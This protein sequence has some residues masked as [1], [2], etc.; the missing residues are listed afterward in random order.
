[1][2]WRTENSRFITLLLVALMSGAICLI[3]Q[4]I[5]SRYLQLILGVSAYAVALVLTCFMLGLAMGSWHIGRLMDRT[6]HRGRALAIMESAI[7]IYILLSPTI[8]QWIAGI[9]SR[10][11][12]LGMAIVSLLIPTYLMGGT[13][14]AFVRLSAGEISRIGADAGLLYAVNTLGGAIGAMLCGFVLIGSIGLSAT[15]YLTGGLSLL[16]A[17]LIGFALR[18]G[19]SPAEP[20]ASKKSR[21]IK[22]E[23]PE[24]APPVM[25]IAI[26]FGICGFTG[27]AYEVF[28]TRLLSLF[29]KDS[30]YDLT[31]VLT[32][33]LT[34][35]AI[36]SLVSAYGLK[37]VKRPV[38]L[39]AGLSVLI[40]F[41]ALGGL[42]LVSQFPYWMNHLQTN[43]AM[44][45]QYQSRYWLAGN[46][47]RFG[48]AMLLMFVPT[49]LFGA[50]L[51]VVSRLGTATVETI[52]RRIG[53]LGAINT[54]GSALGALAAG[55]VLIGAMGLANGVMLMAFCNVIAGLLLVRSW[56]LRG[57]VFLVAMTMAALVPP[58]D[59]MRMSLSFLEPDQRLEDVIEQQFYREDVHGITAVVYL[60]PFDRKYLVTNRLFTQNSSAMMGFEDHR[61]LGHVPM[62][63]HPKPSSALA[64]GLGA[65][66]T[67]RGMADHPVESI[68]CVEL[69]PTVIEAARHF[70]EE[71]GKVLDNP[72]VHMIAD[73]ARHFMRTSAKQYDVIVL[74]I[75]HPMSGG[76]SMIFSREYYEAAR[77]RL[78]T[79]GL[80][81]QWLPAHQLSMD[82]VQTIA[83]TFQSVFPHVSLWFGLI[84]ESTAVVGLIGSESPLS[85]DYSQLSQR[86]A[87]HTELREFELGSA[88][89]VLS[90]FI[91]ADQRIRDFAGS[92]PIDRDDR[93]VV[94]MG[95][96]KVARRAREMGPLNLQALAAQAADVRPFVRNPPQDWSPDQEATRIKAMVEGLSHP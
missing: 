20:V 90:H 24:K 1:M 87:A 63:L 48:Y 77:R 57:T 72:R 7:G 75:F 32:S 21:R 37:R 33:Y 67:L 31:I 29:F 16:L 61:R 18:R 12:Q 45:E 11:V 49:C 15:L 60:K 4:L 6:R 58:W 54:L 80:I 96:P 69:S 95:A 22:L 89:R 30:I 88:D 2:A 65:G 44:V 78:A 17:G 55:F 10:S 73:D 52:G 74:D 40:G 28:W 62:L 26:V 36:G 14:P 56:V 43:S 51:P 84:G 35:L 81:C 13:F 41:S 47:V 70:P 34:G 64:V 66:I 19:E 42:Y 25:L 9:D 93:P 91:I 27:L 50:V 68:D 39:L 8:Y 92:A 79:G 53:L 85:I 59:R 94:E 83:A 38:H 71:N 3:Y 46:V 82:E 76:S 5:W 86:C 23:K